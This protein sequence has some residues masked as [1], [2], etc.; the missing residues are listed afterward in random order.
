MGFKYTYVNEQ[1]NDPLLS[2]IRQVASRRA[3]LTIGVMQGTTFSVMIGFT[4]S[5][6]FCGFWFAKFGV[7]NPRAGRVTNV[8]D[9]V[10]CYQAIMFGMFTV[11]S[12]LNIYPMVVRALTSGHEVIK[13]IDR[14]PMIKDKNSNGG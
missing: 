1:I 10:S 7:E 4:T 11:I 6:W 13:V 8:A 2:S 12:I 3:E 14:V 5:A 9:I